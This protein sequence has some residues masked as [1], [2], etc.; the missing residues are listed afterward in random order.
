MLRLEDYRFLKSFYENLL[1]NRDYFYMFNQC[2]SES[3]LP[4][5][6]PSRNA[7]IAKPTD[8]AKERYAANPYNIKNGK[9]FRKNPPRE[10]FQGALLHGIDNAKIA[11][12]WKKGIVSLILNLS[13]AEESGFNLCSCSTKGCALACLHLSGSPVY[14]KAK[15]QSRLSNTFYLVKER[16]K[17]I[18]QLVSEIT[19]AKQYADGLGKKLAIRLNGTSDLPWESKEFGFTHFWIS[20]PSQKY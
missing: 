13:P 14:Q 18:K 16:E 15:M 5:W 1:D 8:A 11:K 3:E 7:Y 10:G 6:A 17:F 4:P 2:L 9:K 19:L 12:S 20:R